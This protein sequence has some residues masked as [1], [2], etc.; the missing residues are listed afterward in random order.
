MIKPGGKLILDEA[1]T[2]KIIQVYQHLKSEPLPIF[3]TNNDVFLT[4]EQSMD[5]LY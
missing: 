1:V 5:N 4:T 2:G 3:S